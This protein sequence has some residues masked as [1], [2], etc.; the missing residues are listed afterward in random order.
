MSLQNV[1]NLWDYYFR[2]KVPYL[3]TRSPTELKYYGTTLTGVK[4]MDNDIPNQEIITMMPICRMVD[5]FKEGISIKILHA[6][7]VET[8]YN[9]I[10][11][12]LNY[13]INEL[14]KGINIRGAPIEDL[15]LMDKFANE[16]YSHAKY[17]FTKNVVDC[18]F[19]SKLM[20]TQSLNSFN[21]FKNNPLLN[22]NNVVEANGVVTIN[23]DKE[24]HQERQ[25]Y[26]NYFKDKLINRL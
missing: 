18:L 1:N 12:H 24:R 8:I 5:L 17:H 2:V 25:S 15:I 10:S 7:D 26:E 11:Q 23:E 13:W 20:E 9:Y 21:F 6:P 4:S 19:A 16:V 14:E 22:D 3:A